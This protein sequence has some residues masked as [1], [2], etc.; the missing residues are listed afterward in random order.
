MPARD[1][2]A[3]SGQSG[4]AASPQ[5]ARCTAPKHYYQSYR[6]GCP[7]CVEDEFLQTTSSSWRKPCFVVLRRKTRCSTP[8]HTQNRILAYI[9]GK[10]KRQLSGRLNW[11]SG[12]TGNSFR[13]RQ[14]VVFE[15]LGIVYDSSHSICPVLEYWVD[16]IVPAP[17][18]HNWV[19]LL[20]DR[21]PS[22]HRLTRTGWKPKHVST[23]PTADWRLLPCHF[24]QKIRPRYECGVKFLIS[25][26]STTWSSPYEE[27]V[28]RNSRDWR[29]VPPTSP[30]AIP[31]EDQPT[32]PSSKRGGRLSPLAPHRP[33]LQGAGGDTRSM[34]RAAQTQAREETPSQ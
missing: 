33:G 7:S 4:Q 16:S 30:Q 6:W 32:K 11:G 21:G 13:T 18:S 20:V 22:P 31:T 3:T 17:R 14:R 29:L 27:V 26:L 1:S 5:L 2:N 19:L 25:L 15:C 24:T 10:T 34:Q 28:W 9:L 12:R 23:Q 8:K